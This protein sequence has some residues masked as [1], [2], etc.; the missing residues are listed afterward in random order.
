M[1]T[2]GL[3]FKILTGLAIISFC[4]MSSLILIVRMYLADTLEAQ[5][6]KR[7]ISISHFLAVQSVNPILTSR[8][9]ALDLMLRDHKSHDSDLAYIFIVDPT[10]KPVSHTFASG[11]PTGLKTLDSNEPQGYRAARIRL[12]TQ[13]IIDVSVPIHGEQLG[14]LHVGMSQQGIHQEIGSILFTVSGV[15]IL[16]FQLAAVA[17]WL[18]MERVAIRPVRQLGEQV[19]QLGMG[20]FTNLPSVTSNDEIGM[21]R[22]AFN[23]MGSKLSS[24]YVQMSE[25]SSELLR[26]NEQLEQLAITD[27][28]TGLYNHRHFYSRLG[29]E[30]KRSHRYSHPLS[31]IIAD[32]DNFKRYND[33][34]G[35]VSG[36]RILKIM[37]RMV[38]ENARENDLAARYGGEEFAIILPE[39]TLDTARVVAE[40]MRSIIESSPELHDPAIRPGQPITMSFGVA[41]LDD[42]TDNPKGFVRLAD[43]MLYQAKNNGRNRVES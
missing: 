27:E 24:L 39:T 20:N 21:L 43:T 2:F 25:R 42:A 32:I 5:L 13:D 34:C 29:E 11:F 9:L 18:Y 4:A 7:G 17:L 15:I 41:Q 26:L 16:L 19:R 14:R 1:N 22:C 31:L 40:R 38:A 37:A 23:D 30:V 6:I 36:D 28:L 8:Y 3:R 12:G 10:H 35:H 33:T